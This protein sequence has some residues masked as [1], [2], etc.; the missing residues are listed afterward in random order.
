MRGGVAFLS[1][2]VALGMADDHRPLGERTRQYLADL[3]RL[4]TSNPPG[5][6]TLV[7]NYLK[8]VADSHGIACDLLGND[9]TRLS[10]VARLRGSGEG[11]SPLLLMAHSDVVP[12]ER[13]DWTV[14]P[15]SAENRGGFIYGRGTQDDKSLL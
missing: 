15:F 11:G 7:A 6:E 14:D 13:A 4:D 5:N 9:P 3:V 8:Q 12:A 10:F 2:V 1:V